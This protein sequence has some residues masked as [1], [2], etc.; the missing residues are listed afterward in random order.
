VLILASLMGSLKVGAQRRLRA[1]LWWGAAA[2]LAT[3][4]LTWLLAAGALTALA[5]YG[6][7]LEA[8]V[9][10]IAIGVLLLITNWFF[11]DVYWTGWMA[12]F[13]ARKRRIIGGAAGQWLGLALLG[14]SSIYREGFET[15][16]FLQALVL[17]GGSATVMGGVA[18]GLATTALIG[19]VVFTVQAR[20]PYKKMLIVTGVMIGAVLLVMVGNT[21]H[22]LQ[23]VGWLPTHPL[24][25][26][27]LP[28]W[29]GLWFG[30]FPTWEGLGLQAA[31]AAFVIGSYYLAE[32][33]HRRTRRDS[34]VARG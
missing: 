29:S 12:N 17:E 27:E 26:L 6:E 33:L 22:V 19:L 4:A 10:L 13:H 23:V 32:W 20:L 14:F 3:S 5:R 28:F 11:H 8:V 1:P 25:W 9:S 7:C 30:V 2:A 21:A 15:V 18:V 16:L 24:R 34:G 31:A